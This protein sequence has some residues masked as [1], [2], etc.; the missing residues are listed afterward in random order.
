MS[1]IFEKEI[2]NNG[3]SI[4]AKETRPVKHSSIQH[5]PRFVSMQRTAFEMMTNVLKGSFFSDEILSNTD[6]LD[7]QYNKR[8]KDWNQ[9]IEEEKNHTSKQQSTDSLLALKRVL[10][11]LQPEQLQRIVTNVLYDLKENKEET[12]LL[13]D[14]RKL[15][16]EHICKL[17]LEVLRIREE[18]FE[19]SKCHLVILARASETRSSAPKKDD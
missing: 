17:Q 14:L 13:V 3:I 9:L 10:E 5:R 6:F 19:E 15:D 18:E 2:I 11:Q 12:T 16:E 7:R 4:P 1:E 8:R